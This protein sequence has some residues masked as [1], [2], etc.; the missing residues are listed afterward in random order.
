MIKIKKYLK[1]LRREDGLA[2]SLSRIRRK[3]LAEGYLK[4][5]S[6]GNNGASDYA[7]V[8]LWL[9][10]NA[11]DIVLSHCVRKTIETDVGIREW[12][13]INP[14]HPV[15]EETIERLNAC[16]KIIVGGGGLFLP[17]TNANL[18][19]GWQ[20]PVS[21]EQLDQIRKPIIVYSV[22]YN[23]FRGQEADDLFR[24]SVIKLIEKSEFV[25]LRNHGSIRAI[26]GILPKELQEKVQY[27]PCTTTLINKVSPETGKK[28]EK[29]IVALNMAF[30]REAMRYGDRK[31]EILSGVAKAVRRI[32]D[33]GYRIYYVCHCGLDDRFLPYL[34]KEQVRYKIFDLSCWFP[35][36]I[37]R[38]YRNVDIVI[39]MRGHAQMIPFGVNT[40]IISLGTHDKMKW[41]LEDID[42]TEWYIN[43][44]D[45]K[46]KLDQCI[47]ERFLQVH[48]TEREETRRKLKEKQEMLWNITKTNLPLLR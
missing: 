22:G 5:E 30:D 44:Q 20:W 19:S 45:E 8:S 18:I 24:K 27:Q 33:R 15:T 42:A 10:K 23:Y 35:E 21:N 32:Q 38:F 28:A 16:H 37:I 48:E 2:R 12:K 36:D 13:Y 6:V 40:E 41:F 9:S 46:I 7:H 47:Y 29:G 11:G 4:K 25:G 26:R 43:L 3:H 31:E 17:D 34:K 1:Q 39:G 14:R